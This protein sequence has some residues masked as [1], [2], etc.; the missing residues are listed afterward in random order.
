MGRFETEW[1]TRPENLAALTDLPGR[2]IDKVNTQRPPRIV[3]LD[4]DSSES[5]T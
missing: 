4:M 1:L 2:W 5:P 3:V